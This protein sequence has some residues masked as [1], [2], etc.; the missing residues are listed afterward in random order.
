[1]DV[2]RLARGPRLFLLPLPPDGMQTDGVSSQYRVLG[3]RELEN[4]CSGPHQFA[5]C[6]PPGKEQC[7]IRSLGTVPGTPRGC[8][9]MDLSV[10]ESTAIDPEYDSNQLE[11]RLRHS[12]RRLF[13]DIE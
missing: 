10:S 9:A 11:L 12:V 4:I 1:M 3:A 6:Q 5:L 13:V 2:Y 7:P 8:N